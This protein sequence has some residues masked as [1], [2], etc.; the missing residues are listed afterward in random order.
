MISAAWI[1][2]KWCKISG[3]EMSFAKR[4][5][6]RNVGE[7]AVGWRKVQDSCFIPLYVV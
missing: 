5:E 7:A 4:S 6:P 1:P 2:F 3:W